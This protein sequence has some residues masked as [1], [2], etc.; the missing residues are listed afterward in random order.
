MS[1]NPAPSQFRVIY[2][3]EMF[4]NVSQ[5]RNLGT[6]IERTMRL[7]QELENYWLPRAF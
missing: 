5:T 7:F 1:G 6:V 2:I 4:L 3:A